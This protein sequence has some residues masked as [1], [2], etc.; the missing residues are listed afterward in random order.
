VSCPSLAAAQSPRRSGAECGSSHVTETTF[1]TMKDLLDL[2]YISAP[3]VNQ[4]DL[5]FRLLV[6]QYGASLTYT[7]MLNPTL[8]LDNKDYLDFHLRDLRMSKALGLPVV[9][10]LCG[11]DTE[12]IVKGARS[13]A[14][15]C[16]GIGT[17][18]TVVHPSVRPMS[19]QDCSRSEPWVPAGARPSRPLWC[20][21]SRR[22]RLASG[23][24]H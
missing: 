11:N 18:L 5:P 13:V 9:V 7:Q 14:G 19:V 16:D 10:Q 8:L 20:L 2:R 17:A 23:A 21:P 4:S 22:Q 12:T 6:H 1:S 3:M 15:W 24:G